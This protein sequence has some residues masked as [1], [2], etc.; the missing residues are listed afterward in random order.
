[1]PSRMFC[2][3]WFRKNPRD[4]RWL[5]P[6]FGDNA[7]VL[8]WIHSRYDDAIDAVDTPIG[9]VPAR[10]ALNVDGLPIGVADLD[11]LLHVDP[12]EWLQ[13]IEPIRDFYAALADTLPA[14]LQ[15]QL[16]ALERRLLDAPRG[17]RR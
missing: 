11:E 10:D 8:E 17:R 13:E 15:R 5:W 14:A 16:D 9:L 12:D 1:M 7:R 2:V 3:N 4:G 6:G